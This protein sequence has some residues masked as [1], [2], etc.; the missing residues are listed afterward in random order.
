MR[1]GWTAAQNVSA[2]RLEGKAAGNINA[3]L[4]Q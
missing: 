3:D 2:G 4:T 1:S